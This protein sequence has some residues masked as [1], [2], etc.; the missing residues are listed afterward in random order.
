MCRKG[1][2]DTS[3]LEKFGFNRSLDESFNEDF[4]HCV[5][6]KGFVG[7]RC[8]HKM[9][10]CPGVSHVC[11]NGAQ[12]Q[13]SNDGTG[14]HFDCNCRKADTDSKM[15]AGKY[16]EYESTELCTVDGGMPQAPAFCTNDGLCRGFIE[17]GAL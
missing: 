7:L 11:L 10:V 14:F 1:A 4:E 12:C 6:P 2:K 8:E 16:C 3:R 17:K 13:G 5:C 15:F 9:D